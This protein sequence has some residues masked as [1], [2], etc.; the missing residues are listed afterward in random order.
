MPERTAYGQDPEPLKGAG[1]A[2]IVSD[3]I[4]DFGFEDFQAAGIVGNGGGE[5]S[6]PTMKQELLSTVKRSP[7]PSRVPVDWPRR[8]TVYLVRTHRNRESR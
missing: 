1:A 3:L 6:G 2:R 8:Q 4:R 5:I 7:R